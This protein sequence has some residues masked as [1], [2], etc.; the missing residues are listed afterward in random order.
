VPEHPLTP[1]RLVGAACVVGGVVLVR[2]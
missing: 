2:S 1:L